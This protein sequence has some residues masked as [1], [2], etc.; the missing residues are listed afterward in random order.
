MK[1]EV[2][3][4]AAITKRGSDMKISGK[5]IGWLSQVYPYSLPVSNPCKWMLGIEDLSAY[6]CKYILDGDTK[7]HRNKHLLNTTRGFWGYL[8]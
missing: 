7:I 5:V 4:K 3:L 1:T 8:S 6:L 2:A